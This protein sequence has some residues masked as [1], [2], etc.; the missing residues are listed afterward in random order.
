MSKLY[1]AIVIAV[2]FPPGCS[3]GVDEFSTIC[4]E[5]CYTG[6]AVTEGVGE[7][8]AGT[9]VCDEDGN[10]VSCEGEVVPKPE[11]DDCDTLDK[12]CDGSVHDTPSLSPWAA[13][14][15]CPQ[16]GK[17]RNTRARCDGVAGQWYCDY[18]SGPPSP[19]VCDGTFTDEDCDCMVDDEDPDI[20]GT[21]YGAELVFCY[22]GPEGTALNGNCRPGYEFCDP[23]T[24]MP[25]CSDRTPQE[26]NC[27]GLDMDCNGIANDVVTTYDHIAMVLAID[28]SGSMNVYHEAV[29][30]VICDYAQQGSSEN[31][32]FGLVLIASP[33]GQFSLA[34]DLTSAQGLCE[35]LQQIEMYGGDEPT[36]SAAEAVAN[37]EN[38][39][40]I[41]W[42]ENAKRIFVGFGDE[43][44]AV[45]SGS[46]DDSITNT[47]AYC[48]A[49]ETDIYWFVEDVW[50][51]DQ[52][53]MGCSGHVFQ[54]T[55]YA[56]WMLEDMN[57]IID[58]VCLGE[59]HP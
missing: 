14:N 53:A 41:S 56:P 44:A 20:P 7:C 10:V 49:S 35:A 46:I 26:E 12:D 50:N 55:S 32:L 17:C 31:Y 15:D 6:P 22:T 19:E 30:E 5:T 37:P 29:K 24:G 11:G 58:S 33:N 8:K 36:L 39:L 1:Y 2:L 54:L 34:Q 57:K 23:Y 43:P 47:L 13:A 48:D 38:P 42:P 18:P 40:M 52:Q 28:T 9:P 27:S 4:P 16:C 51:Y 59:L 21:A 3:C 25:G 45:S